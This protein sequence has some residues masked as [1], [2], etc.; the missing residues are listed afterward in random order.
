M[1][2]HQVR[3]EFHH[4]HQF[5][6]EKWFPLKMIITLPS[7]CLFPLTFLWIS[8]WNLDSF[9]NACSLFKRSTCCPSQ[10]SSVLCTEGAAFGYACQLWYQVLGEWADLEGVAT[11]VLK[12][13]SIWQMNYADYSC[14]RAGHWVPPEGI[15]H[16]YHGVMAEQSLAQAI[17]QSQG[18][19]TDDL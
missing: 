19:I 14:F 8:Q 13:K 18:E 12:P 4:C 15:L 2:F 16:D 7:H 5:I 17:N 11:M 1:T 6:M 3:C 9:E 10:L